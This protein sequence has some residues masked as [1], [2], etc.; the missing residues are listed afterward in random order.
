MTHAFNPF[1]TAGWGKLSITDR[2]SII[3]ASLGLFYGFDYA[4]AHYSAVNADVIEE[5]LTENPSIESFFELRATLYDLIENRSSYLSEKRRVDFVHVIQTIEKLAS[6]A[7]LNVTRNSGAS[8][9]VLDNQINLLNAFESPGI[10]YFHLPSITSPYLAPS[11]ARLVTQF[12]IVAGRASKRKTKVQVVIDEFQRMISENLDLL[13]QMARSLDIGLVLANQSLSDLKASGEKLFQA[14][15]GNCAIRQWIS[16]TSVEDLKMIETLFGTQK[17]FRETTVRNALWA[18]VTSRTVEDAPRITMTDLHT[19][20][21]D[22][23][24]SI[25]KITGTRHG[26]SRY[27]GIPFVMRSHFHISGAE[28][29]RRKDFKWPTDLPGLMPV[30]ETTSTRKPKSKTGTGARSSGNQPK[31]SKRSPQPV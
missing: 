26:Y 21:D 4:R 14:I 31:N 12:L 1:T 29:Q 16:V 11:V 24:L 13:F 18:E 30:H 27:R 9:E 19:I 3:C 20:S 15:E 8:Q 7:P 2:S 17:E 25:V 28:Y 6:C 22:P 10:Y 23:S 5:C